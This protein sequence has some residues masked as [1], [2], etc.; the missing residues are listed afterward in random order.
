MKSPFWRQWE[1]CFHQRNGRKCFVDINSLK[2]GFLLHAVISNIS[3]MMC[4]IV[5]TATNWRVDWNLR[6]IYADF[7]ACRLKNGSGPIIAL[8]KSGKQLGFAC[9]MVLFFI[10]FLLFYGAYFTLLNNKLAK[11]MRLLRQRNE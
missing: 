11:Y 9:E 4:G 5:F 1:S 8:H 3:L 7:S 2:N 6:R 10:E